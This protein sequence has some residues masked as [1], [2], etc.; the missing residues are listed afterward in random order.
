MS[1]MLTGKLLCQKTRAL[2]IT[3]MFKSLF[4]G[5]RLYP[6]ARHKVTSTHGVCMEVGPLT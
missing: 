1:F 2:G 5:E 6:V 3:P 4:R